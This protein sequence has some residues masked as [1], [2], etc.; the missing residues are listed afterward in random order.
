[1]AI[2]SS[3]IHGTRP[4]LAAQRMKR[5]F[6]SAGLHHR[7]GDLTG[8][9]IRGTCFRIIS[10]WKARYQHRPRCGRYHLLRWLITIV[11][12]ILQDASGTLGAA[13]GDL[14]G[15]GFR[16]PDQGP[17]PTIPSLAPD[18]AQRHFTYGVVL[19]WLRVA[20]WAFSAILFIII[21]I[22]PIREGRSMRSPAQDGHIGGYRPSGHHPLQA[23]WR[24]TK[25]P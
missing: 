16:Q 6:L 8:S 18:G 21:S 24:L 4:R 10:S 13:R 11:I 22:L 2:G 23:S 14:P 17:M 3:D 25:P 15:G 5:S 1:M 20:V 7:K 12:G 9:S 19:A